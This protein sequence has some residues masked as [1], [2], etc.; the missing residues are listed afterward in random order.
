MRGD[1]A[2]AV[3]DFLLL[4]YSLVMDAIYAK[5]FHIWVTQ[6]LI[7]Y[8]YGAYHEI[9]G[10]PKTLIE[11]LGVY[12]S[13]FALTIPFAVMVVIMHWFILAV[14]GVRIYVDNFSQE[15]TVEDTQEMQEKPETGDY[16]TTPFTRY[17]IFCGAYL[18][19]ASILVYILLN[20]YWFL[21]MYQVISEDKDWVDYIPISVKWLAFLVDFKAYIAVVLLMVPVIPF[22][23][24]AF[25][26]DYDDSDFQVEPEARAPA[27]ILI[28]FGVT[29]LLP[30]FQ[31]S[32][33]FTI[34]IIIVLMIIRSF[35]LG[36]GEC[37][38]EACCKEE[39]NKNTCCIS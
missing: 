34:I 5:V 21:E 32:I 27:K 6:K 16:R 29:F 33:I 19:F 23:V 35:L 1:D 28:C 20:K 31:A 13:P 25:L 2:I 12:F 7:R 11:K 26:P 14:I 4:L 3:I 30:N 36:I 37:L 8:S 18:P 15:K 38:E 22:V 24:G 39:R 10:K 9:V 17:M